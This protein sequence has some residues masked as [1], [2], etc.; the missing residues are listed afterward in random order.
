[1]AAQELQPQDEL[2][3]QSQSLTCLPALPAALRILNLTRNRIA[4]LAPCG[5]LVNLERL[6]ASRRSKLTKAPHG[7]RSA[8][9]FL[10]KF[11]TRIVVGSA[12]STVSDRDWRSSSSCCCSSCAAMN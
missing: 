1:M 5:A 6:D 3:I 7:A 10:V 2:D 8:I 11:R 9:R 4:D 12:G